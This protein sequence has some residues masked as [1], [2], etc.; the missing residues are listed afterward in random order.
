MKTE[1]G[2]LLNGGS[3][4]ISVVVPMFNERDSLDELYQRLTNV[5]AE[6]APRAG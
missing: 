1:R 4:G 5:L 2:N 3:V 6:L